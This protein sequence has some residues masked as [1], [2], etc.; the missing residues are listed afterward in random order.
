MVTT[1]PTERP[2][3]AGYGPPECSSSMELSVLPLIIWDVNHYY[4][5]L[6]VSPWA[7][8]REI[9]EAYQRM[10]G[11]HQNHGDTDRLTYV[12][13]QLL[14]KQIRRLYD[15]C[16]IGEEFMDR[17]VRERLKREMIQRKDQRMD[18]L[19]DLGVDVDN[20]DTSAIE[21]DIYSEMGYQSSNP[22][23][24]IEDDGDTPSQTVDSDP[25]REQDHTHPAER[26]P[27]AYYLLSVPW[28]DSLHEQRLAR[29]QRFLVRALSS[30]GIH[31]KFSVGYHGKPHRWL[32]ATVGYRSVFFLGRH[33][34]PTEELAADAVAS[35]AVS[36]PR[37]VEPASIASSM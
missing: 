22:E 28:V 12:V 11:I 13:T 25:Q 3:L 15:L 10:A 14:N 33:E 35:F 17:Y 18:V 24:D 2:Y 20:L 8:R 37:T 7:T 1:T 36:S 23:D 26:F 16:G 29:W 31:L 32:Y 4:R 6:G 19:R 27:Y 9:R 30:E 21:R 5:D 34:T